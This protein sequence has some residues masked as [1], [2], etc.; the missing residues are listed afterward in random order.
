MYTILSVLILALQVLYQAEVPSFACSS[1]GEVSELQGVR[2]DREA[3]EKLLYTQVV[4]GQCITI[5]QGAVVE[6]TIE[7][8]DTTVL[9]INAQRDPP[10]YMGPRSDFTLIK[11]DGGQ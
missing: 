6:G 8:A 7:P 2:S 11:T 5:G 9:R 4:Y 1:T 10:G 3:F